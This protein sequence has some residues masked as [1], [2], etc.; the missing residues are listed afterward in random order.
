MTT[1]LCLKSACKLFPLNSFSFHVISSIE[2]PNFST[3]S[4]VSCGPFLHN[5]WS[6]FTY[7]EYTETRF[8]WEVILQFKV[9][10]YIQNLSFHLDLRFG[11]YRSLIPERKTSVAEVWTFSFHRQQEEERDANGG[12]DTLR[13]E[14]DERVAKG[15]LMYVLGT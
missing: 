3:K 12:S 2:F 4:D 9:L 5:P 6:L 14:E 11:T 1:A 10:P 7:L 15:E 8:S 13:W